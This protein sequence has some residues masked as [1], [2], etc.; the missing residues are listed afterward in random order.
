MYSRGEVADGRRHSDAQMKRKAPQQTDA[1]KK[2]R[3]DAAAEKRSSKYVGVS[4]H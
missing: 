4:W 3:Q 2:Q 1:A